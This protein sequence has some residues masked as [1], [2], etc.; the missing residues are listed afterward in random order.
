MRFTYLLF[1]AAFL[2]VACDN[3]KD[4]YVPNEGEKRISDLNV[5]ADF[6]W[7]TTQNVAF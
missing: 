4:L 1:M 5:P 2:F 3:E 6:D 7:K